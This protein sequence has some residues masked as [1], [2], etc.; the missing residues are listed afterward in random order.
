MNLER[1]ARVC[2][3]QSFQGI[4][5]GTTNFILDAMHKNGADFGAVLAEAQKLGYAEADPSADIDG[6]DIQRKCVITANVAFGACLTEAEVPVLGIRFVKA[7]DI[8]AAEAHGRVCRMLGSGKGRRKVS[9]PMWSPSL[10][11]RG[12]WRP[13]CQRTI[14]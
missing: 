5:N 10:W 14:T 11:R 9:P 13:Q 8:T 4:M 7:T 1:V 6:L 2:P 3:A 12:R